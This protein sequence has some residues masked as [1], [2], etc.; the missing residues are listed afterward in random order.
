[1]NTLDIQTRIK[2]LRDELENRHK[3]GAIKMASFDGTPIPT[4]KLQEELYSLI[5]KKTKIENAE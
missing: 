2:A 3:F 5:Y 4:E 1:M